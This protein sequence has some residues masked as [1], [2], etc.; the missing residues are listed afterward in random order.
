MKKIVSM[1]LVIIMLLSMGCVT[2]FAEGEKVPTVGPL[3]G[4]SGKIGRASLRI[5]D[6]SYKKQIIIAENKNGDAGMTVYNDALEGVT[7]D[8]KTNTL[9]LKDANYPNSMIVANLMGDDFKMKV[10]GNCSIESITI[11]SARYSSSLNIIGTGTLTVNGSRIDYGSPVSV[12]SYSDNSTAKLSIADTVT[13]HVYSK[14]YDEDYEGE[15]TPD[16]ATLMSVYGTGYDTADKAFTADGKAIEGFKSE[17]MKETQYDRAYVAFVSDEV[18]WY[19]Y[20]VISKSDPDGIYCAYEIPVHDEV[21]E[22][23]DYIVKKFLLVPGYD[24]Y[25]EDLSF[26]SYD[27]KHYSA[28]DFEKEFTFAQEDKPVKFN[29]TSEWREKNFKGENDVKLKKLDDPDGVYAGDPWGI[30]EPYSYEN[31]ESYYIRRVKW[32]D[33]QGMYV[34]DEDF[35]PFYCDTADLEAKGYQV[36]TE[37]V[38]RNKQLPCWEKPAPS[39]Q[40]N[41]YWYYD[42]VKK[43]SEPDVLCAV[44][45][46]FTSETEGSGKT[47]KGYYIQKLAYDSANDAYY[48]GAD[49]EIIL[50]EEEMKEQGYAFVTETVDQQ[51]VIKC[52]PAYYGVDD[53]GM[54][55][56]RLEKD[57]DDNYCCS[58]WYYNEDD[59]VYYHD[60]YKMTYNEYEDVYYVDSNDDGEIAV[61]RALTDAE[62][63]AKYAYVTEPQNVNL[64]FDGYV[65]CYEESVYLDNSGKKYVV[66]EEWLDEDQRRAHIYEVDESKGFKNGDKT[67][68]FVKSAPISALTTSRAPSVRLSS[69]HGTIGSRAPSITISAQ[70]PSLY[71]Q[72]LRSAVRS[73]HM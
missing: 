22:R 12:L 27:G 51:I 31:P 42:Y 33:S 30:S 14:V 66:R 3:P 17:R 63:T 49:D 55:V 40:D 52:I 16:S 69:T 2:A 62:L 57:G 56:A 11:Q 28:E 9:T 70:V 5:Y 1:V 4:D 21:D 19:D 35:E 61:E 46:T 24:K 58:E 38:T 59:G 13:L 64:E 20:K 71:R 6:D 34:Q 39:Y 47:E 50:T 37:E 60:V 18:R 7:Y 54:Y 53:Y 15:A 67:Y 48:F 68:C 73:H 45:Y 65:D 72:E 8:L 26:G 32:D 41:S 10:E 29:V 43:V 23:L 36:E 44:T 25:T